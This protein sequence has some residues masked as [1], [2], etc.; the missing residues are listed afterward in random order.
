MILDRFL[1]RREFL[2]RKGVGRVSIIEEAKDGEGVGRGVVGRGKALGGCTVV[3]SS[4]AWVVWSCCSLPGLCIL[5]T[6]YSD[7]LSKLFKHINQDLL[8]NKKKKKKK[9]KKKEKAHEEKIKPRKNRKKRRTKEVSAA[10]SRPNS[11]HE[12][13]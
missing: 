13:I 3:S 12:L 10:H 5:C 2:L 11:W 4:D 8:L 1:D 6:E 7:C 9:T